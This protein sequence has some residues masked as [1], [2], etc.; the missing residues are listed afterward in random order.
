MLRAILHFDADAFFASVEQAADRHLRGQP[1]AVGGL[2]RGIVASASY[3]AR[4]Y[5]VYTPMPMARARRLCPKLIVVPPNFSL[6]EQFS[7]HIFGM[8]EELTPVIEKQS[9]DE[10]YL[11][12]TGTQGCLGRKPDAVAEKLRRDVKDWLKVTI[13]QGLARN[14]L[15]SQIAGKLH[16][17]NGLT[18]VPPR[19]AEELA[20][21]HP[22][23]VKWLPGVGPVGE[24]LFHSAGLTCIGQVARMPLG[25]LTELVGHTARQL[26]DFACN[27]DT[28][29]VVST[30]PEALSYGHQE[31]FEEDTADAGFV[32][33]MLRRL[34]D[35]AFARV[36][37]DGK[38]V[39]TVTVK[40]RYTDMDEHQG[41]MSFPEPTDVEEHAYPLLSQLL[42]RLW[43]R[44]VRLRM[45]QVKLS[46]VYSGFSQLDL[47]GEKERRRQVAVACEAI[48]AR[49][50]PRAMMR[51]HDWRV[52]TGP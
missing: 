50:G 11:D 7:A 15:L 37:A 33:A 52:L 31:T 13:S 30:P 44:R 39:R 26:R 2:H 45:V 43:D 25:W 41:Q 8:A 22:L 16:K 42:K 51:G 29:P 18:I 24:K 38:Q 47:F 17:P 14:K 12:L 32:D 5:G 27:I 35:K 10:G 4:R 21:L 46:N 1:V 20:F 28:R 36:R 40:I 9:V 48:R 6:Y 49:F 3:E 23:A 19:E 34:V